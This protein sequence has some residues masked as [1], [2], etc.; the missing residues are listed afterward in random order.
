MFGEDEFADVSDV[1]ERGMVS[2]DPVGVAG[3]Q[4]QLSY[5]L[6]LDNVLTPFANPVPP[7][8]SLALMSI[9]SKLVS[10]R[11]AGWLPGKIGR[12]GKSVFQ[13]LMHLVCVS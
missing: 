1:G 6:A 3:H 10:A 7:I 13:T 12:R 9:T 5:E 4:Y 2:G 8:S 11:F